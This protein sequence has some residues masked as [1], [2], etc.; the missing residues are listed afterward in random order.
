MVLV[1]SCADG[2]DTDSPNTHN[3]GRWNWV[4]EERAMLLQGPG[5]MRTFVRPDA[6][7]LVMRADSDLEGRFSW[8][9]DGAP[10]SLTI[11]RFL[12]VKTEG[13]C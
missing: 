8:A 5:P 4:A 10:K 2:R 12:T 11:E 7:T 1:G 3:L 9:H 6:D 13:A